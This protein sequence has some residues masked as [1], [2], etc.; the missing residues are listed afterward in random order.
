MAKC[1]CH[2]HTCA[3]MKFASEVM[4]SY[5]SNWFTLLMLCPTVPL[6]SCGDR[7]DCG[8]RQVKPQPVDLAMEDYDV[9]LCQQIRSM[10]I[11]HLSQ[12]PK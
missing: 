1:K 6:V 3:C 2:S 12:N 5:S 11:S 4:M 9:S 7:F 8:S 10:V